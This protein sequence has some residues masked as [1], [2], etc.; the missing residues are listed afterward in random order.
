M[1]S[2]Y[3]LAARYL[4]YY[5]DAHNSKGH[6]MHSPFVFDFILHVLNNKSGYYPP[7]SIAALREKMLRDNRVLQVQDLGAGS[8][9]GDR[10]QRRISSIAANAVKPKKYGELLYRL[11]KHYQP[12]TIV[13]LGTSLGITTSYLATANSN[14]DVHTIEGSPAIAEVAAE[15]FRSLGLQNIKSHTGNFDTVLPQ[16]LKVMPAVDFAYVDGNHLYSPTI[17]YFHVLLEKVHPGSILVFDDIHWSAEM[18]AAWREI[19][20][21]PDVQCTV[22]I[23]FL[24]F[25]FFKNEFRVKQDFL[26]RF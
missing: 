6:G 17:N 9:S 3:Q 21:H 25:V 11:A 13:E 8:R 4:R 20:Q 23:F 12:K 24:G 15:N 10:S 26:I 5:L 18:E 22:D 1:Y 7:P 2:K 16:L 19:Q 14:A